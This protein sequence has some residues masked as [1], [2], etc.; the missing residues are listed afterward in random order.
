MTEPSP[1]DRY[2]TVAGR[3]PVLEA[4]DDPQLDIAK[5]LLSDRAQGDPI[6]EIRRKASARNIA[7]EKVTERK[8]TSV[9]GSPRHHQGVVADIVAPAMRQ[10]S[11]FLEARRGGREWATTVLVLDQLHN[12]ANVGMILRSAVAAGIDGVVVPS[13]GT[14]AIGPITIK[15][16]AGV[17]FRAPILR[18]ETVEDAVEQLRDSRFELIG[19]DA[20]GDDI[21]TAD[22]GDRVAFV[23]GNETRGLSVA[24]DRSVAIP[25]AGGVESLNVSAA[26]SILCFEVVRRTR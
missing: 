12:P 8:V 1:R 24:V 14:A 4:L 13:R 10:L 19:L 3:N 5:I 16:S 11:A 25:L 20:G 26:A 22:F 7:V 23:L 15:A 17:A 6:T 18:V 2:L 9:A 21:Y